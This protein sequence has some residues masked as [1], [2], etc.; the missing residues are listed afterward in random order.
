MSDSLWPHELHHARIPCLSF[1]PRVCSKSC[2]LNWWCYLTI[3]FS[4]APFSSCPQSFPEWG[5]FPMSWLFVW[6]GQSVGATASASVLPMSIQTWFPLRFMGLISLP[7][8][9]LSCIY[10]PTLTSVHNFDYTDLCW[11]TDASAF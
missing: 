9:E 8:K 4:A 2:P 11:H 6:G 1:F 3:L 5:S 7:F 10:G